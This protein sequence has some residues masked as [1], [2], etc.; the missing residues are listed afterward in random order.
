[1]GMYDLDRPTQEKLHRIRER[2]HDTK[3]TI[4]FLL[5]VIADQ[6]NMMDGQ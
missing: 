3:S 2:Y 5:T 4:K 6:K 1:M